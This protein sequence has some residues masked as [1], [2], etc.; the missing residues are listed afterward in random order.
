MQLLGEDGRRREKRDRAV[1]QPRENLG[2]RQRSRRDSPDRREEQRRDRI[3]RNDEDP[4]TSQVRRMMHL[5]ADG[6][7][8]HR[9][10]VPPAEHDEAP[11][12]EQLVQVVRDR[13]P[14]RVELVPVREE[15]RKLED[16]RVGDARLREAGRGNDGG[17]ELPRAD[18]LH[19]QDFVAGLTGPLEIDLQV[20]AGVGRNHVGPLL[21]IVPPRRVLRQER[22]DLERRRLGP[23]EAG[24]ATDDRHRHQ[25][26]GQSDPLP[27]ASPLFAHV[28]TS[29]A[30]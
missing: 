7:G 5:E 10:R 8:F 19:H 18:L 9:T 22:P 14:H 24:Q 3:A 13:G 25:H 11:S 21:E 12:L 6:H 15:P 28:R 29:R 16:Q 26:Q 4:F 27:R 1:R 2:H 20:T 30:T 23:C 17:V